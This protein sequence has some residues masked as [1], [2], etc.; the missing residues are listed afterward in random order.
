MA[1]LFDSRFDFAIFDDDGN[2]DFLIEFQG[3][4][5]YQAVSKFGGN[6]G[7]C[8]QKFNDN[9]KRRYCA[10]KGLKLIEIPYTEENLVSYDYIMR[11]AGY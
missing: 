2:L 8:Q 6:R 3:K 5:H 11:K 7:L 10:L 1:G 9:L 4:Q